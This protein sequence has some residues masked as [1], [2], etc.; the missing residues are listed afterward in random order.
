MSSRQNFLDNLEKL[1]FVT[2]V[3]VEH[4]QTNRD[5]FAEPATGV[6]VRQAEKGISKIRVL[7]AQLEKEFT[8]LEYLIAEGGHLDTT[9]SPTVE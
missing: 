7:I 8:I 3:A 4:V 9:T 1:R 5:L 2:S 6:Q